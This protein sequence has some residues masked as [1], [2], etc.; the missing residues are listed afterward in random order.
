VCPGLLPAASGTPLAARLR[1]P[2]WNTTPLTGSRKAHL[3]CQFA[4]GAYPVAGED[5]W[6]ALSIRDDAEWRE[7]AATIG[8]DEL[9]GLGLDERRAR[10]DEL[11][12]R[13]AAWTSSQDPQAAVE[14]LQA[15]RIPAARVLDTNDIHWDPQLLERESWTFPPH[16]HPRPQMQPWPQP[17]SAWR[18]LAADPR[19]RRHAPLFGEH[20]RE[21][22]CGLLEVPERDPADL[23]AQGVIGTSPLGSSVG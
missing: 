13:I 18:L 15:Q 3:N 2:R 14:R 17:R 1:G 16:P 22:L 20:N 10:H 7:F 11:D 23:E 8:A 9:A 4:Q 12:A 19:P 5:G 21:I 6:L